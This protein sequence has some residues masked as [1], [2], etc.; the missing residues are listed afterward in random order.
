MP[1]EGQSG[2][3]VVT[4]WIVNGQLFSGV[5]NDVP[6]LVDSLS[7]WDTTADWALD[8]NGSIIE[9][10]SASSSYSAIEVT[11][12]S[13]GATAIVMLDT[14]QVPMGAG[15][16]V[17]AGLHELIFT[18]NGSGCADT[19]NVEAMCIE[20]STF[21]V[22]INVGE[23][24]EYCL[25]TS[26]LP[27]SLEEPELNCTNCFN[28]NISIDGNN[29]VQYTG[30]VEGSADA[31]IVVCDDNNLCDTTFIVINILPGF[32]TPPVAEL[33]VRVLLY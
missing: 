16:S 21:E 29:C 10:G 28:A 15:F 33:D 14:N 1:N 4:S 22:T 24:G 3:Y 18:E 17:T 26:E 31:Y 32:T 27:G 30:L 13:N 6:A 2:P 19:I 12:T 11:Q 5:F 23:S 9:G 20:S 7:T 25:D 8:A